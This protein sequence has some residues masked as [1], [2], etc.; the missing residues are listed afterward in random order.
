MQFIQKYFKENLKTI[1]KKH[2][3]NQLIDPTIADGLAV[4]H[5]QG[6]FASNLVKEVVDSRSSIRRWY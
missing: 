1:M 4:E 3:L 6:D 2:F 5:I